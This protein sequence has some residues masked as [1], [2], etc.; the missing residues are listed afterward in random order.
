MI[1]LRGVTKRYPGFDLGP[2]DLVIE[3]GFVTGFVG[4]NGA[5]KT[6]T[7]KVLLG[8]ILPDSGTVSS[9][10]MADIGVVLDVP[11]Y[12][13][14]W[15]VSTV[16]KVL[17]PFYPQWSDVRFGELLARF[18]VPRDRKV[19]RLS[20]GMGMKLQIAAA[21]AHNAKLLI[22]DEPT[23]GLDPLSRDELAE[24]ISDFMIDDQRTVLFSSHITSDI[25]RVA[26]YVAVIDKGNI[27]AYAERSELIDSYR[28]VHGGS[29][30]PSSGITASAYGLRTH[31]AGWDALIPFGLLGEVPGD[32][33]SEPPTLNDLVVRIARGR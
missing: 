17:S 32:A 27:V 23:S 12:D 24:I 29:T 31:A 1:E 10:D 11:S 13:G 21:F 4:A 20:R 14:E 19:K 25:D 18:D 28:L 5:G 3:E 6:T 33:L 30:P 22:L 9:P 16:G 7:I 8:M 2:L 26:D 15:R